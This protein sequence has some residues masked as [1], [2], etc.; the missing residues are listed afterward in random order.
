[1]FSVRSSCAVRFA[2]NCARTASLLSDCA[3]C[4]RYWASFLL[5]DVATAR[6]LFC[7]IKISSS[8]VRISSLFFKFLWA[9]AAFD[10]RTSFRMERRV[11]TQSILEAWHCMA[12][13]SFK[14]RS[15]WV[16]CR[17]CSSGNSVGCSGK[18]IWNRSELGRRCS[19]LS[20]KV[21]CWCCCCIMGVVDMDEFPC[22]CCCC[23]W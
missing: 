7:K 17:V 15:S 22:C 19:C 4:P 6:R 21:D 9:S 11:S 5:Y 20:S 14:K 18:E 3:C 2:C 16:N 13:S 10:L 1:M 8:S 23:C 12:T